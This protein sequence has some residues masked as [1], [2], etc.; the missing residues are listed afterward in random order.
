MVF[1]QTVDIGD[2]VLAGVL[3][4][5]G[6]PTATVALL[7]STD[8]PALDAATGS[9]LDTDQRGLPR[10]SGPAADIGAFERQPG[11]GEPVIGTP[12]DDFLLGTAS[13]ERIEGLS[14]RDW[15]FAAAGDDDIDGGPDADVLLGEAGDDTIHGRGGA[16]VLDGGPGNDALHGGLGRDHVRGGEGRDVL[17]GGDHEDRLDGGNGKD[18][19]KGGNGGDHLYGGRFNDRL[20]G[21]NG[22]DVLDGARGNDVLVGGAGSDTLIGGPGADRFVLVRASHEDVIVDWEDGIDRIDLRA[23]AVTFADLGFTDVAPGEVRIAVAGASL[24][25]QDNGTGLLASADFDPSDFLLT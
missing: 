16:D 2:G 9:T 15:V 18:I 14:G 6:G 20:F 23:F 11:G 5:N 4:D 8:N 17:D 7:N 13:G 21:E 3:A 12:G 1:A 25:V 19:L 24:L 22:D 10:P